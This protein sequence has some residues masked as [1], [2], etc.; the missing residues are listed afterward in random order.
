MFEL[1]LNIKSFYERYKKYN[2]IAFFFGGFTWDSV[3]LKRIDQFLDNSI[4]LIYLFLLGG[5]IILVALI[6]HHKIRHPKILK[7]REWYPNALQFFLGSLFSAY[8]I[9]YFKSASLSNTAIYLGLLIAL[10]VAN[11]FLKD[12]LKNIY[13]LLAL[14]FL[15][16]FSFF[17]FFVPV[18]VKRMNVF[19]FTGG[20]ILSVLLV[21][22]VVHILR[23]QNIFAS[24]KQFHLAASLVA[25]LFVLMNFFYWQNW[26]PP[27]PLSLKYGGVYHHA[28]KESDLFKLKFEQPRWYQIFKNSDDPFRYAPGDTV[29]CFTAVFA[30][31]RLT[32]KIV[33]HWQQFSPHQ[34]KWL[35]TDRLAYVITGYR[36]GGYRGVTRKTNIVPG[37]WRVNVETE[38]GVL[39]GRI[40]F[41]IEP[42]ELRVP[43]K[44]I[45]VYK[46]DEKICSVACELKV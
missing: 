6:E 17:I 8:V 9:F 30:P 40:R 3:T 29:V 28:S 38:E 1:I 2:P 13:L 33:H 46:R 41:N 4:L 12:R 21:L 5:L 34:K 23:K 39:L 36:E 11:E 43:L 20:G 16:A 18:L 7:Y 26:I 35:T 15:A 10:L 25:G 27:V 37:E 32:K 19:T 24:R 14:Y 45:Y 22:G 44:T 31:T 42:V